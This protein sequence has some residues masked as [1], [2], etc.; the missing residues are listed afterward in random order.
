MGSSLADAPAVPAIA[1]AVSVVAKGGGRGRPSCGGGIVAGRKTVKETL[2][3]DIGPSH[4][5]HVPSREMPENQS[6]T[7]LPGIRTNPI[8][9][10]HNKE[11]F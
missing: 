1:A 11:K 3:R 5:S 6:L 10:I 7:N 8:N 4:L 2:E 9:R